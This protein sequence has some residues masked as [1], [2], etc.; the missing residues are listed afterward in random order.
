[1]VLQPVAVLHLRSCC[2]LRYIK[3]NIPERSEPRTEMFFW[4]MTLVT[5]MKVGAVA[6]LVLRLGYGFDG[7][8]I[9]V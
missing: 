9:V 5:E 6:Q 1:M 4:N 7:D 3:I 8:E 2:N